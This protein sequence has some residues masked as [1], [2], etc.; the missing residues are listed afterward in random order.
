MYCVHLGPQK[1]NY[2]DCES[3]QHISE[4]DGKIT[5]KCTKHAS[6]ITN[7]FGYY[8][9]FPLVLLFGHLIKTLIFCYSCT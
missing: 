6:V 3:T 5:M 7:H 2:L 1:L 8:M 4:S 9:T